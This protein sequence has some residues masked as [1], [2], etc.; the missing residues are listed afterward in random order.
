MFADFVATKTFHLIAITETWLTPDYHSSLVSLPSYQLVRRDRA[1]RGGGVCWYIHSFFKFKT[2]A[3][4]DNGIEQVWVSTSLNKMKIGLWV[5]YRPPSS[6]VSV[7][8]FLEETLTTICAEVRD[9]I[10]V[11]D[12]NIDFLDNCS[13]S[14]KHISNILECFNLV[15][16]IDTPTRISGD[17]AT[18][19]D[20]MCMSKHIGV[21]SH[22]VEEVMGMSDHLMTCCEL[23][24][25]V[26]QPLGRS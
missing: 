7:L 23:H 12:F 18:L 15:Q 3:I 25:E 17:T 9:T 26:P 5:F 20:L 14:Y 19:I 24:C 16:I 13:A 21:K 10:L 22:M 6:P 4:P 8:D 11:G 2:I 1:T